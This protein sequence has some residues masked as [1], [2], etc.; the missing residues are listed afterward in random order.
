[1]DPSNFSTLIEMLAHQAA[2]KGS[3][4]AFT[5][6]GQATTFAELWQGINQFAAFLLE[7]GL[8]HGEPVVVALPNS[9]EFF[10][11][12][13]GIQRAGGI[14][15]PVFPKAGAERI[16]SLAGRCGARTIV[17]PPQSTRQELEIQALPP[18]PS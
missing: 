18:A 9:A 16:C 10:T 2:V 14:A 13:Y 5:F 1:M 7:Q 17:A 12:F 4:V 6:Q 3:R 15:V 11:T 8:G